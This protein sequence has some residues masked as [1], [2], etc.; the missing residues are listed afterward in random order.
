MARL[1]CPGGVLGCG[2][3]TSAA[4]LGRKMLRRRRRLGLCQQSARAGKRT[5]VRQSPCAVSNTILLHRSSVVMCRRNR[6]S[7]RRAVISH[8]RNKDTSGGGT[9]E[10]RR[11]G[12]CGS[13]KPRPP[14]TALRPLRMKSSR[15]LIRP[16]MPTLGTGQEGECTID[17]WAP[18]SHTSRAQISF[19]RTSV[20]T[21]SILAS[22][23]SG[24]T[25]RTL[26]PPH[27]NCLS[28]CL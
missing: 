19:A 4:W 15:A 17:R 28:P 11:S 6:V 2:K 24:A 26:G 16:S 5:D 21:F 25:R 12:F 3:C 14:T 13:S 27:P 8:A 9:V 10:G 7:G 23:L 1:G 22:R 18:P 20:S